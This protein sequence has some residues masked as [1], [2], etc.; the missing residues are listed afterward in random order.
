MFDMVLC[1]TTPI[2]R[3]EG[4]SRCSVVEVVG[5]VGA[6]GDGRWRSKLVNSN[7]PPQ[8]QGG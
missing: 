8:T 5:E 2:Y 4:G 3:R 1:I 6:S 7:S